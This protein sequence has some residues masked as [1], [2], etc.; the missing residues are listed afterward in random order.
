MVPR[1]TSHLLI[2][3]LRLVPRS[4]FL[5]CL[6]PIKLSP[7]HI[8]LRI[9]S[10]ILWTLLECHLDM[11][12]KI[13]QALVWFSCK[14]ICTNINMVKP[15]HDSLYHIHF[16]LTLPL[17]DFNLYLQQ[18]SLI[19]IWLISGLICPLTKRNNMLLHLIKLSLSRTSWVYIESVDV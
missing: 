5:A 11:S 17:I 4:P 18:R 8:S 9:I 6:H 1:S 10:S 16:G 12:V 14:H 2:L 7:S 19:L 13:N 3:Q 15:I